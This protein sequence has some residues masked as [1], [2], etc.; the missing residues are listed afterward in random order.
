MVDFE[1]RIY[2]TNQDDFFDFQ[3][4]PSIDNQI[5]ICKELNIVIYWFDSWELDNF[6]IYFVISIPERIPFVN[7]RA[8]FFI[9]NDVKF[10]IL[11]RDEKLTIFDS[12]WIREK[13]IEEEIDDEL[14]TAYIVLEYFRRFCRKSINFS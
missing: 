14:I 4:V 3:Y 13:I 2:L 1:T 11:Q 12:K 9:F 8:L 6:E 5:L 10:A 7:P